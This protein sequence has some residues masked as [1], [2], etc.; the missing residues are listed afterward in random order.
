MKLRILTS[1][2]V[3]VVAYIFTYTSLS[4]GIGSWIS[5]SLST[6]GGPYFVHITAFIVPSF[7]NFYI[8][9]DKCITGKNK[10]KERF[11]LF[12]PVLGHLRSI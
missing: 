10:E 4:R 2:D 8:L 6:S 7:P 9:T 11:K 3:T 5:L 1:D 12:I